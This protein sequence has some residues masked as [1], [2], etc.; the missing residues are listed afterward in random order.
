M[1]MATSLFK[2]ATQAEPVLDKKGNPT[3]IYAFQGMAAG[4]AIEL[5]GKFLGIGIKTKDMTDLS[6][7]VVI[8]KTYVVPAFRNQLSL[9]G[10]SKSDMKEL[11]EGYL[12]DRKAK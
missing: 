2:R 7:G 12:K 4:K 6:Q 5:I 11:I 8:V 3:G 9:P 1:K 10:E